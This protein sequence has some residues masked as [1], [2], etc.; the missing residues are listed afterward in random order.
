MAEHL[1]LAEGPD[2]PA[3]AF[4]SDDGRPGFV[5][6]GFLPAMRFTLLVRPPGG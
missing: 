6:H 5:K 3:V 2:L 4:T 1:V